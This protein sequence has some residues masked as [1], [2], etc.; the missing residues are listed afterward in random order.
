MN[1][2]LQVHVILRHKSPKTGAIEEKHLKMPPSVELDK[3]THVYTI[4][5]KPDNR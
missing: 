3:A 5:I 1:T 2:C 4:A